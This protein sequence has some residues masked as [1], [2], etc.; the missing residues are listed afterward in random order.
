MY[1]QADLGALARVGDAGLST[2]ATNDAADIVDQILG[3]AS[4]RGATVVGDG[5]L[6]GSAVQLLAAQGPTVAIAAGESVAQDSTSGESAPVDLAP[7]R[8]TANVVAAPFDPAVAA[9]LAGAGTTPVTPSYLDASLGVP[10]AHDSPAARREDAVA[11]LLWRALR[12]QAEPRT[13][14]FMPPLAWNLPADDAQTILTTLASSIRSGLAVPRPLT[15][16]LAEGNAVAPSDVQPLPPDTLGNPRAYIDAGVTAG[17]ANGTGRLWGLTAALTVDPRTGLTGTQYT[18]PL[19]E[20][21]LR[22]LSQSVPPDARNG[23]ADATR[24]RGRRRPST[25]CSAPSRSS[26]RAAPTRWPPSAAPYRW[27][28]ATTSRC[29]SGCGSTSTRRRG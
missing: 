1:A 9:A 24:R 16:L 15:A 22:A 13:E 21:M 4:I 11:A 29:P 23:L 26:T 10:L 12:P 6:T 17:I 18:A 19:R 25:T 20:D 27:P 7:R 28:C 8:Y 14:I 5:P 2:I 3:I